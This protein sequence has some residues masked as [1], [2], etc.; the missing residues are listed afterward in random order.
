MIVSQKAMS[1]SEEG[2]AECDSIMRRSK[3]SMNLQVG[4][5]SSSEAAR[6]GATWRSREER[7][8]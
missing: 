5:H 2:G 4:T 7:P 8:H 1:F 6:L 3:A